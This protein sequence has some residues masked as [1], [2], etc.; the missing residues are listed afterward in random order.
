MER[1]VPVEA[2]LVPHAVPI[3]QEVVLEVV[4]FSELLNALFKFDVF[5]FTIWQVLPGCLKQ[6]G[7]VIP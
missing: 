6:K 3:M 2:E 7:S 5:L 1:N 4:T